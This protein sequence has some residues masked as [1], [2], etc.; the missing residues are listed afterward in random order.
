MCGLWH[1]NIENRMYE[2]HIFG[3]TESVG[4]GSRK[5]NDFKRACHLVCELLR[6]V[7]DV[8]IFSVYVGLGAQ[9]KF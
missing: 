3:K 5:G 9:G 6:R 7:H 2:V 1:G 8:K 4:M